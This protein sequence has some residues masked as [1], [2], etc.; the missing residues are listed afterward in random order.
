M[1]K[2]I[3]LTI[4]KENIYEIGIMGTAIR[5]IGYVMSSNSEARILRKYSD[6]YIKPSMNLNLIP[7]KKVKGDLHCDNTIWV[8]WFQGMENAPYLVRKCYNSLTDFNKTVET[9]VLTEENI[10]DYIELPCHIVDLYN[11]GIIKK[12]HYSDIIRA[13][14]LYCYGG[15]WVDATMFFTG[16]IPDDIWD[17]DM[18]VFKF[19]PHESLYQVASSQFIRARE[20]NEILRRTII[21][22]FDYWNRNK[23]LITYYLFHYVFASAVD[24]DA[25][26]RMKFDRVPVMFAT[27]NH[28][29]QWRLFYPF[30]ECEWERYCRCT[31]V[32]KLSYKHLDKT[33]LPG[34]FYK[35]LIDN[36]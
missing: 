7:V 30:S 3:N 5:F 34:T 11:R 33:E 19:P 35:H 15:I 12:P 24:S 31:F 20:G 26:L 25:E 32:H 23:K 28:K 8:C 9:R 2:R 4:I 29:L 17:L 1:A 6:K 21:G 13:A 10:S 22:L 14:I 16:A 27:D 18:F 36:E